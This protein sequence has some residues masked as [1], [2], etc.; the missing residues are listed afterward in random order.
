MRKII[1]LIPFF[2]YITSFLDLLASE[3]HFIYKESENNYL[4]IFKNSITTIDKYKYV[5]LG[6]RSEKILGGFN[7]NYLVDCQ[8]KKYIEDAPQY[9]N[10]IGEYSYWDHKNISQKPFW[11]EV[12]TERETK[13]INYICNY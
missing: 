6:Y 5:G 2:I 1:I 7:L 13:L 10:Q 11:K 9:I 4:R 12:K 3:Y 8:N